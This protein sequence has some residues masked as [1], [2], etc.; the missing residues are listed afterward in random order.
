M[1][2]GADGVAVNVWGE[3][4]ALGPIRRDLLPLYF[5]WN[6]DL[7]VLAT[8]GEVRPMAL[9]ALAEHYERSS[10]AADEVHFTVYERSTLRPVGGAS[11]TAITARTATFNLV[12]G[13]KDTWGRGYGTEATRLVL[14]F[15]FNALGLH[16]IMLVVL[17]TNQRG[18]RAYTRAGFR[19]MGRRREA[20]VR[21][22]RPYDLIYM[23]CLAT[24]FESPVL[25]RVLGG[26]QPAGSPGGLAGGE[27]D[28]T[29][30]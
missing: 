4:V 24:E 8:L 13:E 11:L 5:K 18:I 21:G 16:N 14:D 6:N 27:R 26:A 20:G 15:G 3:K 2:D 28:G 7:E 30:S 25:G 29:K 10:K 12:I 9:E 1:E 23:D 22:G 17:S 19:V